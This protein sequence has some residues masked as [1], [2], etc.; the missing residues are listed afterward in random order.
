MPDTNRRSG[1]FAAVNPTAI[2]PRQIRMAL[3]FIS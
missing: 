2:A 3:E 1:S